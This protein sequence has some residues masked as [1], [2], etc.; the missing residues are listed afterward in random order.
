M[1]VARSGKAL[2]THD[3]R[4]LLL[5]RVEYGEADLIL[6]MLGE[7]T[8]RISVLARGARKS[9]KRFGG[10]LEPMHT[11]RVRADERAGADLL[12]LREAKIET[13]RHRL[14]TNLDRLDAA[15]RGLG[16][17]R[18]ASPPSTPEHDVWEAIVDLLSRLDERDDARNART[19][20]AEFGLRLLVAV[21]WGLDLE[22]CV[23]CAKACEPTRSALIDP[24]R[25]GLVC[26]ACGGARVRLSADARRRLA[27]ASAGGSPAL[28]DDDAVAALDLVERALRAHAGFE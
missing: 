14:V 27:L 16:W 25:G 20:L 2:R 28:Q 12:V 11:L 19:H 23:R 17:V 22:R 24:V 15:G 6:T 1:A 3:T 18:R 9:R 10:V 5:R 4:A 21:G 13:A 8:G 7:S 26:R